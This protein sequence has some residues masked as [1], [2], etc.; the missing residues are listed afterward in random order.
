MM[1]SQLEKDKYLILSAMKKFTILEK[2]RQ[3][4]RQTRRISSCL[5]TCIN[6]YVTMTSQHLL[7]AAKPFQTT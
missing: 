2:H 5:N 1:V 7:A 4:Y 3:A 6:M